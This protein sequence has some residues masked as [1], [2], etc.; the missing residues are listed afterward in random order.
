MKEKPSLCI[1]FLIGVTLPTCRETPADPLSFLTTHLAFM[2]RLAGSLAG[3]SLST[4]DWFSVTMSVFSSSGWLSRH[5]F[6]AFSNFSTLP[7]S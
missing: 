5:W 4:R 2:A 7:V 3:S 6:P 1:G